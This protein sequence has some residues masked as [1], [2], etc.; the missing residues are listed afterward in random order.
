MVEPKLFN[1]FKVDR[2]F[3][4]SS[5]FDPFGPNLQYQS[6]NFQMLSHWSMNLNYHPK[7]ILGILKMCNLVF[8]FSIGRISLSRLA[9]F[10]WLLP[11]CFLFIS[12]LQL[13]RF[14]YM[15]QNI[16]FCSKCF[17]IWVSH[18]ITIFYTLRILLKFANM[19]QV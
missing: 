6:Q 15:L 8:K 12:H 4:I 19:I 11:L 9:T 5:Y 14:N 2:Y 1:L 18:T 13:L 17:Q 3:M 7:L 16:P 10:L